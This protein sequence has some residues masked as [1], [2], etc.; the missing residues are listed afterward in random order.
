MLFT[1]QALLSARFTIF[2]VTWMDSQ[3]FRI[4]SNGCNPVTSIAR[5]HEVRM[6]SLRTSVTPPLCQPPL[7][8]FSIQSPRVHYILFNLCACLLDV[9]MHV[10]MCLFDP[11]CFSSHSIIFVQ[12]SL[13]VLIFSVL[14]G[15][16]VKLGIFNIFLIIYRDF[17]FVYLFFSSLIF[18]SCLKNC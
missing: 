14:A 9:R 6:T 2:Y 12:S 16:I 10:Y 8:L 3:F 11:M 7:L 18:E 4:V 1:S 15:W 5:E 13:R 17:R